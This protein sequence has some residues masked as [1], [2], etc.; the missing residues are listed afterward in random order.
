MYHKIAFAL[1]P[2]EIKAK[3]KTQN[4]TSKTHSKIHLSQAV[5]LSRRLPKSEALGKD[6][7]DSAKYALSGKFRAYKLLS[8]A[9]SLLFKNDVT[10]ARSDDKPHRTRFCHCVRR[11]GADSIVLNVSAAPGV[12]AASLSGVQT[13]GSVWSCPVCSRRIAVKRGNEIKQA[14]AYWRDNGKL[15]IMMTLTASHKLQDSL[16]SIKN[17]FK[18]AWRKLSKHGSYRNLLKKY[19]IEDSIKA[20]E[21]TR[22]YENG[23]H[24]H[25]HVLMAMDKTLLMAMSDE[26]SQALQDKLY[27]LWAQCLNEQGMYASKKHG[28]VLSLHGNVG[29]K[30]L[31]KLGLQEDS[32]GNLDY[33][34]SG[35][36]NKDYK[37]RNIWAILRS[38]SE[39]NE[40]DEL[41]Y[42]E[43]VEAMSG[44]AWI[45]WSNGLKD[46][47]GLA[48]ASDEE[49]SA[50][51][52]FQKEA[53]MKLSDEEFKP[54][55]YFHAVADLY[56]LAGTTSAQYG[57]N[58]AFDVVTDFLAMLRDDYN[59]APERNARLLR[60][61]AQFE[62]VNIEFQSWRKHFNKRN[63]H[64]P[65]NH[66]F[67]KIRLKWRSLRTAILELEGLDND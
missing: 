62:A 22:T 31:S 63:E 50:E 24:Y 40:A 37:G 17:R 32:Q 61:K 49:L 5:R 1:N 65:A 13:C 43:Y 38:A 53:L 39:G 28:L 25:Y 36:A 7:K 26:D 15:P 8:Y 51:D 54:V 66:E 58:R 14:L 55:R 56:E 16:K 34:L 30:Y 57:L 27:K 52:T 12:V 20:T 19:G 64:P 59:S 44:D 47:V 2:R 6:A 29:K 21:P 9:Q 48:E 23:W 67:I 10:S 18:Q 45:T 4:L 42:L 3:V 11:H 33:E 35:A 60:L 46:K 41:L